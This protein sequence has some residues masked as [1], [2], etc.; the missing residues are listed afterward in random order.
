MEQLIRTGKKQSVVE[1][2]LDKMVKTGVELTH[3]SVSYSCLTKLG[4]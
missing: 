4:R 3:A 1:R 2:K